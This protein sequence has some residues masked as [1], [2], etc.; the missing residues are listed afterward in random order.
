MREFVT[1]CRLECVACAERRERLEADGA[2]TRCR[3]DPA[4]RAG[5][6]AVRVEGGE[7][8]DAWTSRQLPADVRFELRELALGDVEDGGVGVFGDERVEVLALAHLPCEA[9]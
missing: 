8:L 1:Q 5:G 3:G 2:G 7:D 4:R 6:V 9:G